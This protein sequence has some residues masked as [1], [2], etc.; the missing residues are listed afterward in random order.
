MYRHFHGLLPVHKEV[1]QQWLDL[2]NMIQPVYWN[3]HPLCLSAS[4]KHDAKIKLERVKKRN[5]DCWF[6]Q[7]VHMCLAK[8]KSERTLNFQKGRWSHLLQKVHRS[9][10][11][12]RSFTPA[13]QQTPYLVVCIW[14]DAAA[15]PGR[16]S[17]RVYREFAEW[18]GLI[19][20]LQDTFF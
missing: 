5:L 7:E 2:R 10:S 18:P 19:S 3:F 16:A 20:K 6:S 11:S 17:G 13:P 9:N 14:V 15:R 1:S 8:K 4:C 12:T